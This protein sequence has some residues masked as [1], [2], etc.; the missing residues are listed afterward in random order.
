MSRN[1]RIKD[2]LHKVRM[3]QKD[4]ALKAG[5]TQASVSGALKGKDTN[6]IELVVAAAELTGVDLMYLILG[7][8]QVSKKDNPT[9]EIKIMREH[10]KAKDEIIEL[11]RD[12]IRYLEEKLGKGN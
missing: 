6:S 12:K 10:L 1:Q 11:Q 8:K 4:L 5:L 2:A 3:T 9:D 7:N